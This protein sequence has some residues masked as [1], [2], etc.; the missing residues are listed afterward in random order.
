MGIS[1]L[2]PR[3]QIKER[4]GRRQVAGRRGARSGAL[5]SCAKHPA[6]LS[7]ERPWGVL[8]LTDGLTLELPGDPRSRPANKTGPDLDYI[9]NDGFFLFPRGDF[10]PQM[11]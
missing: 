4:A 9:S 1:N 3:C 11:E 7:S 10:G 6:W 2:T 8:S 5:G